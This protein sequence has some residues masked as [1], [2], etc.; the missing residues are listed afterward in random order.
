MMIIKLTKSIMSCTMIER[1]E[2]ERE[3]ERGG[4]GREGGRR[5]ERGREGGGREGGREGERESEIEENNFYYKP[6]L[7]QI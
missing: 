7:L 2:R 3:R 5:E 4:G 6:Y 1:R